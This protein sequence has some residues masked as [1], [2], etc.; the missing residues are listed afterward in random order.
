MLSCMVDF[1][2]SFA[3]CCYSEKKE[4]TKDKKYKDKLQ[5]VKTEYIQLRMYKL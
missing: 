1:D 2:A 5:G 4:R 3:L